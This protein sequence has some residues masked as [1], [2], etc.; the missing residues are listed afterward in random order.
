MNHPF[1]RPPRGPINLGDINYTAEQI[2]TLLGMIPHK[3]DRQEVFPNDSYLGHF[4]T[5]ENLP[6]GNRF[7]WAFVGD[8]DSAHPYFYYTKDFV[9][10]G[11]QKGW[12]DMT[13]QFGTYQLAPGRPDELTAQELFKENFRLPQLTADRAIA[14]E[15][16]NRI[17][18]T[19]VSREAVTKH[20]RN[21][22]NQQ[23]LENPPLITEGYITPQMLSD[24]TRQLLE[25]S[26]ATINNL[27]DGEDLQSVHGVLKLANKQH[28]PN[29][30]SGL[31]RQYLRNNIVA[32]QNILTQSM[33]Q[34]PNTIYIIQYDYDLNGAEITIPDGCVLQFEG[35]TL[36]NGTIIGNNTAIKAELIKIFSL[37]IN[38]S[39]SW[40]IAS[41]YAEWFGAK[42]DGE[43]DDY[44]SIQRVISFFNRW[45]LA[46]CYYIGSTI[47][48]NA[49]LIINGN[50]ND[51]VISDNTDYVFD[52]TDENIVYSTYPI[53]DFTCYCKGGLAYSKQIYLFKLAGCVNKIFQNIKLMPYGIG[54]VELG[55]NVWGCTF[56]N[57]LAFEYQNKFNCICYLDNTK[58][59]G[60]KL[61]VTN[62]IFSGYE[63]VFKFGEG[64]F[65][66]SVFASKCSFDS[67]Y[68]ILNT[69]NP[70]MISF[71]Q[72]HFE[73][74]VKSNVF[75][76]NPNMSNYATVRINNSY[77]NFGYTASP[78]HINYCEG[79]IKGIIT[80]SYITNCHQFTSK[81]I[82]MSLKNIH[83]D[84]FKN[85]PN[86]SENL[87]INGDLSN[88]KNIGW[89]KGQPY[90]DTVPTIIDYI[91]N[92]HIALTP[93]GG[94]GG[95]MF[96]F[97]S[98]DTD[99]IIIRF[100]VRRTMNSPSQ[101]HVL[102]RSYSRNTDDMIMHNQDS[103]IITSVSEE[104]IEYAQYFNVN[105]FNKNRLYIYVN[106]NGGT[107][108]FYLKDFNI[109][110][111]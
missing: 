101:L 29:S 91:Q 61:V 22:Y 37:D 69:S 96:D 14:D 72:C 40:N 82:G 39:G 51:I 108:S 58:N 18:D 21:T 53:K 65:T 19:Y 2:N 1:H 110:N 4:P 103:N 81:N 76:A 32:G 63:N 80:N 70:C 79:K 44:I 49:N 30:Y 59:S 77:I 11:Y 20:I 60:E 34:W 56:D 26:G 52:L 12:N 95:L 15:H 97:P 38:L 10:E 68:T 90:G 16:G 25:E 104:Y 85:L 43:S 100:K 5:A 64:N 107:G 93:N 66:F 73:G 55:D 106:G 13:E 87:L 78:E 88:A 74:D 86:S 62:S 105:R 75:I 98:L 48:S 67:Q 17:A 54:L 92:S 45:D 27:P 50:G 71:E 89:G 31:G 23:F 7:A 36:S 33:L 28:N 9:P 42:G 35:G 102:M 84:I 99:N 41:A 6:S 8:L 3:A 111:V 46:S 94:D 109:S 47:K 24:E 57:I 83:S